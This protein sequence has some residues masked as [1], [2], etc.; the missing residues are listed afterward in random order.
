MTSTELSAADKEPITSCQFRD[1]ENTQG[2]EKKE[3]N[4]KVYGNEEDDDDKEDDEFFKEDVNSPI[5]P[6]WEERLFCPM[7]IFAINLGLGFE[8][9][10]HVWDLS[11]KKF[12]TKQARF[13]AELVKRN[14]NIKTLDIS[15]NRIKV[16][17][18][19][20]IADALTTNTTLTA[21]DIRE[22]KYLED[23]EAAPDVFQTIMRK[24][25]ITRFCG[26]DKEAFTKELPAH[27]PENPESFEEYLKV[28]D[29]KKDRKNLR[30]NLREKSFMVRRGIVES[31][32]EWYLFP[33]GSAAL[34]DEHMPEIAGYL[35][36]GHIFWYADRKTK[37]CNLENLH[38]NGN[39]ITCTGVKTI[40]EALEGEKAFKL[41]KLNLH[42]NQIKEPGAKLLAKFLQYNTIMTVLNLFNNEIADEGAL[43]FLET[44]KTNTTLKK[45]DLDKNGVDEKGEK[46]PTKWDDRK[47]IGDE[48]REKLVKIMK[49]HASLKYL[50]DEFM[51]DGEDF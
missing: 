18:M 50:G 20:L 32:K 30:K 49:D 44:L 41:K 47:E 31:E 22:N 26:L 48:V 23:K 39:K 45:L 15:K 28:F 4:V 42:H 51:E 35:K 27:K 34:E 16:I 24:E 12:G 29:K 3:V 37:V 14:Q 7:H 13:I 25:R 40:V 10:D 17:G 8:K 6:K 19:N 33:H 38:L 9:K 46:A 21:I 5:P 1:C 2:L 11:D 36:R 43:H